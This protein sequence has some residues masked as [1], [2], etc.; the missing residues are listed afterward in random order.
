MKLTSVSILLLMLH[1]A[2]AAE[3]A[4]DF[5]LPVLGGQQRVALTDLRGKVVYLDFWASWCGPCRKS[6]PWLAELDAE[7]ADEAFEIVAINVDRNPADGLRFL[8]TYPVPFTVLSDPSGDVADDYGLPGLPASLLIGPD[9]AI[10]W[11]HQG[12][13]SKDR[14]NIRTQVLRALSAN[15]D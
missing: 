8:E 3:S 1:G 9:G 7:L 5:Q 6:L 15:D 13:K 4:P 10:V 11:R 14:A 12:F 2:A